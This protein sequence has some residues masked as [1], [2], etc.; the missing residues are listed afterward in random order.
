MK[1]LDRQLSKMPSNDSDG[2]PTE[3]SMH[4]DSYIDAITMISAYDISGKKFYPF[5][6]TASII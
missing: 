4:L 2:T 5:G 1:D 6:R 3:D